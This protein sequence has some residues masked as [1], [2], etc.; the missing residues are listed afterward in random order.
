M[1]EE[2]LREEL[3]AAF[4]NR[5]LIYYH[6]YLELSNEVGEERATRIMRKAIRARGRHVGQNLAK[7]G[8]DNIFGLCE[9]FIGGIPDGG[10]LFE[11]TIERLDAEGLDIKFGRCPLKEAWLEAGLEPEVVAKLCEISAEV[12]TGTFQAAGFDFR[13]DTWTPDGNGCCHLHIRPG[14][15]EE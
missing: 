14:K 3:I 13:A 10:K 8:P 5:A 11:P 15:R 6:I 7:Y 9:A 4:K 12:D 2:K 1:D